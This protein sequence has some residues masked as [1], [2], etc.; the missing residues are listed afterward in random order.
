MSWTAIAAS[1]VGAAASAGVAAASKPE[2]ADPAKTSRKTILAALQALPEQRKVEMAARLGIPVDILTGAKVDKK[3]TLDEAVA[4]GFL[5]KG[6]AEEKKANGETIITVKVPKTVSADFTGYGDADIQAEMQRRLAEVGLD[7]QSKYGKDFIQAALDQQAMADPEGTAARKMLAEQIMEQADRP[8]VRPVADALDAQIFDEL[9][10]GRGLDED[11][12][13]LIASTLANRGG[14]TL[15]PEDVEAAMEMGPEGD[16]RLQ[17][18]LGRTLAYAGS[19]VSPADV[20][21]RTRQQNLSNM[22]SFLSGRTPQSQFASLAGGQQGAT[23]VT[24][25]AQ[26]PG[27][28]GNLQ[29]VG[30]QA[31]L[32]N[33]QQGVQAAANQ[34]SPWFA[35]LAGVV[36][37]AQVAGQ[38]GWQPFKQG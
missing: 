11:S 33:F 12:K 34:V 24:Q 10:L 28:P 26:L 17:Q 30:Q 25:G 5:T 29:Q 35:G 8:R 20:D 7:L 16:L 19:G 32:Q 22:G 38:A 13:G 27:L 6:Q 23:P 18:R 37:G 31:G 2:F 14:T 3:L 9:N 15:T 4:Q 21:Y 36:K 1:V